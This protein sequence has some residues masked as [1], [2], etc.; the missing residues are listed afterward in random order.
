MINE[1]AG[2]DSSAPI[3]PIIV[4]KKAISDSIPKPSSILN[5]SRPIPPSHTGK[6]WLKI[7]KVADQ[8]RQQPWSYPARGIWT[9]RVMS[10]HCLLFPQAWSSALWVRGPKS[11]QSIMSTT[12]RKGWGRAM[13]GSQRWKLPLD[14]RGQKVACIRSVIVRC[15]EC[16]GKTSDCP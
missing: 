11:C 6:G 3:G 13:S 4:A 12:P 16:C 2:F 9:P 8:R 10:G 5:R 1:M 7:S 14:S 15:L